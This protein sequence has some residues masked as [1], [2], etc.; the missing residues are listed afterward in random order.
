MKTNLIVSIW[1]LMAIILSITFFILIDKN[2]KYVNHREKEYTRQEVDRIIKTEAQWFLDQEL[3]VH[4]YEFYCGDSLIKFNDVVSAF[5][6]D[7]LTIELLNH[8]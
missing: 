2:I 7:S 8:K 3:N 6:N 4:D 5:K 1:A